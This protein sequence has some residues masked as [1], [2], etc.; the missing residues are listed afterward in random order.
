[1]PAGDKESG[2]NQHG[3]WLELWSTNKLADLVLWNRKRIEV[4]NAVAVTAAVGVSGREQDV[5][6]GAIKVRVSIM[7]QSWTSD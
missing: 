6:R 5:V 1:M 2:G 4:K 7:G 3:I